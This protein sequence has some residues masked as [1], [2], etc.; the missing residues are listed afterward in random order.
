MRIDSLDLSIADAGD[1]CLVTC[2]GDLDA[3]SATR[4]RDALDALIE[5]RPER[6]YLDC[7]D[8]S[9]ID[10]SGIGAVM[11]AALACRAKG[12]LLTASAN[13]WLRRILDSVGV[14]SLITLRS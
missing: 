4:F 11:H 8:V 12:I 13:D 1:D 2:G 7:D 6:I 9:F 3:A 10:P 5:L 14:A